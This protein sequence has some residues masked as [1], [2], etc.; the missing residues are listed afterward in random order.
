MKGN[1]ADSEH[2]TEAER[3]VARN[4]VHALQARVHAIEIRLHAMEM[5]QQTGALR[6]DVHG[7]EITNLRDQLKTIT[8]SIEEL[9]RP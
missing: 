2:V 6:G 4:Q 7:D 8:E 1:T 3:R 9:A 5:A